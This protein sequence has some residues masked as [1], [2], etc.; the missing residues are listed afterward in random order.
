MKEYTTIQFARLCGVNKCTL[1][2]WDKNGYLKP[3]I[4]DEYGNRTYTEEDYEKFKKQG[5]K[6]N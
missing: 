4:K 6:R 3:S 1:Y 2:R 5:K